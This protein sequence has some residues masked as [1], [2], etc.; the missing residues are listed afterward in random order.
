MSNDKPKVPRHHYTPE[1][2]QFL[3]GV[4]PPVHTRGKRPNQDEDVLAQ[5][6]NR[7]FG[8]SL[9]PGQV[10]SM[11]R[12]FHSHRESA[13]VK[14]PRQIHRYTDEQD[15]A[16]R[17]LGSDRRPWR[18]KAREFNRRFSTKLSLK[19]LQ[20]RARRLAQKATLPAAASPAEAKGTFQVLVNG[21]SVWS[22]P[23]RPSVS[24]VQTTSVARF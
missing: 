20:Q 22:G 5:N 15:Q 14:K 3:L 1:Q 17:S 23:K 21:K 4:K 7:T 8:T 2:R 16:I 13:A 9:T 10:G 11:C 24:V 18:T 19:A 12:Y 6:F